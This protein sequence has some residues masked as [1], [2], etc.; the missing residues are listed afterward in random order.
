MTPAADGPPNDPAAN[1]SIETP[2]INGPILPAPAHTRASK[3]PAAK[4]PLKI[5]QFGFGPFDSPPDTPSPAHGGSNRFPWWKPIMFLLLL[6]AVLTLGAVVPD[7]LS[8]AKYSIRTAYLPLLGATGLL[9]PDGVYG[10][11]GAILLLLMTYDLCWAA[12]QVMAR[13]ALAPWLPVRMMV[14]FGLATTVVAWFYGPLLIDQA[15]AGLHWALQGV[16]WLLQQNGAVSGAAARRWLRR[17][18]TRRYRPDRANRRRAYYRRRNPIR[19]A[20]RSAVL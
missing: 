10:L 1:G 9:A 3:R 7:W 15:L 18:T 8:R 4:P 17:V 2:A 11:V 6:L 20:H 14:A 19:R 5:G 12:K 13:L 16:Q